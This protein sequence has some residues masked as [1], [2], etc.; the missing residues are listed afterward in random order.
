MR[1]DEQRV[2]HADVGGRSVAWAA[3]GSGPPLVVAGWWSSHLAVDWRDA[4]FRRFVTRL[5][6]HARVVRYDRP[7]TGLS[8][9]DGPPPASFA[10]EVAV[11]T[12]LVGALGLDEVAMLGASSGAGV[13]A[14]AAAELSVRRPRVTHLV[15]YGGYARGTDVASDAARAAMLDVVRGHWGLG[16]RVLADVFMPSASAAE[17]DRFARSQR[18]LGTP[19]E[20]AAQLRHAYALDAR[21]VL[22]ALG[23]VPTLVLHRRGDRAIPFALGEDLAARVPNARLV[24]L[25]GEDHLPWLGDATAVVD[26]TVAHLEGRAARPTSSPGRSDRALTPRELEV[27]RLVAA[28]LTDAEIARELVLSPHTVHRHVANVRTKLGVTSRAAAAAWAA[29]HAGL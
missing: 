28:G 5:G 14:G 8:A 16:S 25:A 6:E 19:E 11:L 21:A 3:T 27:L 15:L 10:E 22:P 24:A 2:H 13:A 29:R 17:R 7:G 4:R 1:G 20:A 26:A 23:A 18:T 12:G 9:R